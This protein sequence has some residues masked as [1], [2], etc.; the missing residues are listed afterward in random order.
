MKS[1]R[2]KDRSMFLGIESIKLPEQSIEKYLKKNSVDFLKLSTRNMHDSKFVLI[3]D[4]NLRLTDLCLCYIKRS[5]T[6]LKRNTNR[7]FINNYHLSIDTM[8]TCATI[9]WA[10]IFKQGTSQMIEWIPDIILYDKTQDT[11]TKPSNRASLK[12]RENFVP[13]EKH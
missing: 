9:L 3:S 6:N 13:K 8:L 7:V 1:L 5:R 4:L 11:S 2:V 10:V 12:L